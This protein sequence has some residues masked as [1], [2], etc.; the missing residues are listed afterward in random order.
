MNGAPEDGEESSRRRLLA[1][2]A[3]AL[4]ALVGTGTGVTNLFGG[5]DDE[6]GVDLSVDYSVTPDE[7]TATPTP[8]PSGGGGSNTDEATDPPER[9]ETATETEGSDG[10]TTTADTPWQFDDPDD[11]PRSASRSG[12]VTPG[13]DLVTT[14]I[15]PVSVSDVEP[16]DGGVVDLSLT[17]SG[18]PAQLWVRGAATD[19]DE[20]GVAEAERSAGDTGDPGELQQHIEVRLWYDTDSDEA[21]SDGDTPVPDRL[22]SRLRSDWSVSFV[23]TVSVA[24]RDF[25]W[26]ARVTSDGSV[27]GANLTSMVSLL[28]GSTTTDSVRA[29]NCPVSPPDSETSLTSSGSF[30]VL[31]TRNVRS[32]VLPRRVSPKSTLVEAS[33]TSGPMPVAPSASRTILGSPSST[34]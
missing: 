3:A 12:T 26:C 10:E 24:V 17:L 34:P 16:G 18:S 14:S 32:V 11:D 27:S 8:T 31:F 19:F 20:R 25:P 29:T 30:P 23:W 15:P 6:N 2:L 1:L 33:S 21:A 5:N 7:S 9:S 4:L 22:T 28:F 13:N